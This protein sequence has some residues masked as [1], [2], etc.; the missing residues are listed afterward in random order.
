MQYLTNENI[1]R[2]KWDNAI[3]NAVNNDIFGY[4]WFL[5]II[6]QNWDAIIDDDYK[7]VLPITIINKNFVLNP[8]FVFWTGIFC[9]ELLSQSK[10]VDFFNAIPNSF[11]TVNIALNKICDINNVENGRINQK[12]MMQID[13]IQPFEKREFHIK[14]SDY[15]TFSI[16]I[17]QTLAFFIVNNFV[18]GLGKYAKLIN[19]LIQ[20]GKC[21]VFATTDLERKI[22]ATA[23]VFISNNSLFISS[24]CIDKK[25]DNEILRAKLLDSIIEYFSGKNFV[26]YSKIDNE[27]AYEGFDSKTLINAGAEEYYYPF[28]IRN[29]FSIKTLFSK[30]N[31]F[32]T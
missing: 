27:N 5:D 15:K 21:M 32:G 2:K 25:S 24:V 8:P 19:E 26:L 18:L 12:K 9:N 16:N 29:T 3:S 28:F 23:V 7:N 30:I 10:I 6:C 1:D 4:S 13:L 11:K 20:R 14:T 22:L 31:K 17:K